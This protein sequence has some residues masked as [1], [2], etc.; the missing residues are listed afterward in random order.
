MNITMVLAAY[1]SGHGLT[2]L[3]KSIGS[4]HDVQVH[5]LLH[6]THGET[7]DACAQLAR[8]GSIVLDD[9]RV[10]RGLARSWN[11]GIIAG[12]RNGSDLVMV[13]N[14]DICFSAG[15]FDRIV[16]CA[17]SY[18]DHYLITCAG[19]DDCS[20]A[21]VES[22]E[23]ACFALN[24]VALRFIGCFDENFFPNC[25]EDNDYDRRASLLGMR[26]VGCSETNVYH[27]GSATTRRDP[28][29]FRRNEQSRTLNASYYIKKWGG[30]P[31]CEAYV[32]PFNDG[33][34]YSLRVDPE[35]RHSPYGAHDRPARLYPG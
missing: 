23:Y 35:A 1:N 14:D 15:D 19:W 2:D 24:P 30:L 5:V 31:G 9:F 29:L 16:E 33:I 34:A 18:P 28:E 12:Y 25:Y 10:N 26:R 7:V 27:V 20:G 11:D 8:D 3:V 13:C 21:R 4:R 32:E 17:L 6:S 22:H